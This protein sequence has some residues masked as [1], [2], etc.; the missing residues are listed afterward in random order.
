MQEPGVLSLWENRSPAGTCLCPVLPISPS[1]QS[2]P[3]LTS[4]MPFS[5]PGFS[6]L[7]CSLSLT[8][9]LDQVGAI[10]FH[11]SLLPCPSATLL[12]PPEWP[13]RRSASENHKTCGSGTLW[14]PA[15]KFN[16][17]FQGGSLVHFFWPLPSLTFSVVSANLPS[18]SVQFPP[19]LASWLPPCQRQLRFLLSMRK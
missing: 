8:P 19:I 2:P 9:I 5:R 6:C 16:F 15:A 1:P 17:G 11:L 14:I 7:W 3:D 13:V 12:S 10:A 4:R 18:F